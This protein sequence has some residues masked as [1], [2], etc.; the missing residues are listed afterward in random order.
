[1]KALIQIMVALCCPMMVLCQD[2]TGLWKGTMYND[3]TR[4]SIDYEVLVTRTK[5]K[6]T[7]YSNT[8]CVV[9]NVKYYSIKKIS[10]RI[11]KDGKIVFQDAKMLSNNYTDQQNKNIIQLNVLDLATSGEES[12]L[13]GIFVTNRSKA[14]QSITGRLSIKRVNPLLVKSPLMD[15]LEKNADEETLTAAN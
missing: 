7:G 10:V 13:D 3:S 5:G 6:L 12:L 15:Y 4:Q 8:S 2:I 1:M 11:A 14:Y 9:N